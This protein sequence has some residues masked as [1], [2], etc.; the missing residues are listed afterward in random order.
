MVTAILAFFC[1]ILFFQYLPVLPD[2]NPVITI[3]F[4]GILL[5]IAW[6]CVEI[7]YK[8][9]RFCLILVVVFL[10]G[11]LYSLLLA[12]WVGRW[13]LPQNLVGKNII[14][15]GYVSSLPVNKMEYSKFRFT[16]ETIARASQQTNLL[17]SWYGKER[18][19]V[20]A[21]E[22]W[23]FLVK[24]KRPH[25]MLNPGGFDYEKYLWQQHI[26]ATG[27][28]TASIA[29][30]QIVLANPPVRHIILSWRQKIADKIN[31]VLQQ[32]PLLSM[33]NALVLG[34]QSGINKEQWSIFRDTGTSYLMAIAGLHICLAAG[35]VFVLVQF[36]WCRSQRLALWLPAKKAAAL[37]GLIAAIIYSLLSGF[38]IPTQRALIMLTMFTL[39]LLLQRNTNVWHVLCM[40][41]LAILLFDPLSVLSI[42]FWLS[43]IAVVIIFYVTSGRLQLSHVC[44]RKYTRMQG[45]ITLGLAPFTLLFFSQASITTFVANIFALPGVCL[46]VVPLGLLGS[47]LLLL[48]VGFGKYIL[49]LAEKIMELVWYGLQW[50]S[51]Y[52]QFNWQHS[53]FAWWQLALAIVGLFLLLAPRGVYGKCA[54]VIWFCPLLFCVP[55]QPR[56]GEIWFS[57]L[58][59]GEGL[60]TVIQTQQHILIYDTG[61]KFADSDVGENIVVPFLQ[62]VG[63]THVDTMVISHGDD[64]HSGGAA[65]ILR[66]VT[67]DKIITSIPE[68]FP[69]VLAQNCYAGQAW[70]WD[71]INFRMLYPP[72]GEP[73]GGNKS[74]CVMRIDNGKQSILLPGDIESGQEKKLLQQVDKG[75]L[76][77][78]ILVAPHHGSG[79][80]STPDFVSAVNAKYVLFSAGYAN[81]FHFPSA[82]VLVRYQ[83]QGTKIL[84]TSDS[85]AISFKI[86][87]GQNS[88]DPILYR[89]IVKHYWEKPM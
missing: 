1:G 77:S 28:V 57:M 48:C 34:D 78:S 2:A 69:Q 59:V 84:Q 88:L 54:G 10:L 50:L 75:L 27:Y 72:Q 19:H 26:R 43:F 44:W 41:L 29:N 42:G 13:E 25:G 51:L 60:A 65:S 39:G 85:G 33:I 46:V 15:T 47:L 21:G 56:F 18:L 55:P 53:V 80:S 4:F 82:E 8:K 86:T 61:P 76:E 68:K 3:C 14:V 7:K 12:K 30:R 87:S 5:V 9:I 62:H 70:Q 6:L 37:F 36:L 52:P 45:A 89:N 24:L 71:G 63:V 49:L 58:D 73:Y 16:T 81:R 83:Q 23:Q 38:S 66:L 32:Q 79:T 35:V 40:A 17:L 31:C 11:F 64:D 22:K 20:A 74:S 67:V